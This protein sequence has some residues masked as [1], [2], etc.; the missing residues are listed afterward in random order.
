MKGLPK[1]QLLV[2]GVVLV[3]SMGMLEN[4]YRLGCW[5]KICSLKFVGRLAKKKHDVKSFFG[6][7]TTPSETI[8]SLMEK[9][10]GKIVV[11]QVSEKIGDQ[12]VPLTY[13]IYFFF[14]WAYFIDS[15][16]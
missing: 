8:P 4:P 14:T 16:W 11:L 5:F 2:W 15:K 3:C 12:R 7:P 10:F 9:H 13:D 1:H 6:P